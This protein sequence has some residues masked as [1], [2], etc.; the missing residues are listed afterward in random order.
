MQHNPLVSFMV[1]GAAKCGTS[2]LHHYLVKHPHI[3]GG[4]MKELHF[5]DNTHHFFQ[6][7]LDYTLYHDQFDTTDTDKIYGDF[8]PDYLYFHESAKL[9][10]TYNPNVKLIV[11]LRNPIERAFS[12][13]NM[14]IQQSD[15]LDPLPFSEA[16]RNER[17]RLRTY[18]P[19]QHGH[20]SYIDRGFYTEQI[21][22]FQR[23]FPKNQFLFVRYDDFKNQQEKTLNNIFNYLNVDPSL[24]KYEH[25]IT[26][27]IPYKNKLSSTDHLFLLNIF[28]NEIHALEQL[29]GWDC[30]DWLKEPK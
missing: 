7:N 10:W 23:L 8:T 18:L 1:I 29:L 13:W 6:K 5:F 9:I 24:Y 28:R 15:V 4:K 12:H 20:F 25:K 17:F 11:M 27:N 14:Q 26:Y 16:I 2:A 30:S 22:R 21:R 19:E 3:A